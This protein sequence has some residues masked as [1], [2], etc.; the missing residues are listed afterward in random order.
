MIGLSFS[1]KIK[2]DS[3]EKT[4]SGLEATENFDKKHQLGD[5]G[6]RRVKGDNVSENLP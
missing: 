5:R 2:G 4:R 6:P 3:S 1:A